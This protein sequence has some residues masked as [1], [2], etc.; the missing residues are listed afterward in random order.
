[1]DSDSP[2]DNVTGRSLLSGAVGGLACFE[3]GIHGHGGFGGGGGGCNR[4]GAG[5]GFAGGD[6]FNS[7]SNGQGGT[8]YLSPS[9]T[10]EMLSNVQSAAN[11]GAGTVIIIPAIEGCGCDYRCVALDEYRS[12]VAC[13]CPQ[14]WILSPYNYTSCERKL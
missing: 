7:S 4:G 3:R 8:S 13:I 1:M 6:S 5:G 12:E 10:Y 11:S 14:G 9:R 2:Y